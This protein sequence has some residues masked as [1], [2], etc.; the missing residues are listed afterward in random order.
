M[1]KETEHMLT[2]KKRINDKEHIIEIK[3]NEESVTCINDDLEGYGCVSSYVSDIIIDSKP[4]EED[5]NVCNAG[6]V[7]WSFI[8]SIKAETYPSKFMEACEMMDSGSVDA[9]SPLF[10]EFKLRYTP[11][12]FQITEGEIKNFVY[13][14]DI[15]INQEYRGLEIGKRVIDAICHHYYGIADFCYLK[16]FPKQLQA[17]LG[18]ELDISK[19]DEKKAVKSLNAYYEKIGFKKLKVRGDSYSYFYRKLDR[20]YNL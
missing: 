7:Q 6:T 2:S 3:I 18:E 1:K 12:Y 4:Y 8:N 5:G 14:Q 10:N 16:G 19:A 13:I 9:L 15:E 20:S 11:L 17:K